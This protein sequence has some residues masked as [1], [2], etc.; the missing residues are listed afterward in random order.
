MASR[1]VSGL[2]QPPKQL[3]EDRRLV[4]AA[5]IRQHT[6]PDKHLDTHTRALW[7]YECWSSHTHKSLIIFILMHFFLGVNSLLQFIPLAR[8]Q[9]VTLIFQL[10]GSLLTLKM[11]MSPATL[12]LSWLNCRWRRSDAGVL[13]R[14]MFC[15]FGKCTGVQKKML[16]VAKLG[17]LVEERAI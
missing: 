16:P 2:A 17:I 15:L 9:N 7:M 12:E 1:S 14:H 6:P 3:T 10:I 4:W 5:F 13:L 8:Q 11:L